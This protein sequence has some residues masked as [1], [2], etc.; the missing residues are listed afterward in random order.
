MFGENVL[1]AQRCAFCGRTQWPCCV[2][3][4]H[5]CIFQTWSHM[6]RRTLI[7]RTTST[8][9]AT[10]RRAVA[11]TF[12]SCAAQHRGRARGR[13]EARVLPEA[14]ATV[15]AAN[16]AIATKPP[17]LL[18]GNPSAILAAA[19]VAIGFPRDVTE[20]EILLGW[21]CTNA[22]LRT[23]CRRHMMPMLIAPSLAIR[24][25]GIRLAAALTARGHPS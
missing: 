8:S 12:P 4:H 5:H 18:A 22:K 7:E 23:T 2:C 15:I 20:R 11:I 21:N 13:K 3:I 6:S 17:L 10:G 24:L 19:D 16:P 1:C 14:H 25:A 9:P